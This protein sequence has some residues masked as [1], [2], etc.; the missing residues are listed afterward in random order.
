MPTVDLVAPLVALAESGIPADIQELLVQ[1]DPMRGVAPGALAKAIAALSAQPSGV[2]KALEWKNAPDILLDQIAAIRDGYQKLHRD[3]LDQMEWHASQGDTEETG[4]FSTEAERHSSALLACNRI[5]TLVENFKP[6]SPA[7]APM[8]HDQFVQ[9]A[10]APATTGEAHP[11]SVEG[12]EPVAHG[13]IVGN[14]TGLLWRTWKDGL[15]DWTSNR[16]EATRYARRKDAE[17]AHR[18]DDEALIIVPHSVPANGAPEPVPAWAG[19][20][21]ETGFHLDRLNAWLTDLWAAKSIDL[22][23]CDG[24]RRENQF[25]L[26]RD[27]RDDVAALRA[28]T[29]W[30]APPPA[31]PAPQEPA[32]LRVGER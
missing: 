15:P 2:V 1:G 23:M 30:L 18:E 24:S 10:L 5:L 21:H 29:L 16:D 20:R 19:E 32:S 17:A 14:G 11:A 31:S 22:H 25:G 4:D 12:G 3:C 26:L 8:T 13:W 27:I 7:H 9:Y 6:A 28:A